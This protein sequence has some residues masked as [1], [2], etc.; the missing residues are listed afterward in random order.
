MRRSFTSALIVQWHSPI[1][2]GCVIRRHACPHLGL[3]V[4]SSCHE[5]ACGVLCGARV[6][7]VHSHQ[8]QGPCTPIIIAQPAL[9]SASSKHNQTYT[10]SGKCLVRHVWLILSMHATPGNESRSQLTWGRCRRVRA[11]KIDLQL[12]R[13]RIQAL[14]ISCQDEKATTPIKN[15]NQTGKLFSI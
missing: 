11:E 13:P 3:R 7:K 12:H 1:Q 6:I 10:A 14:Q 15:R 4:Y 5:G 2:T 8:L 9:T